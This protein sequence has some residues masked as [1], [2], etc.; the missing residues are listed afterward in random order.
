MPSVTLTIDGRTVRV[1][2][3][4]SIL[5]A[6]RRIGIKLPTMCHVS[7]CKPR[8]VCRMCVVALGGSLRLVPSCATLVTE[9]MQVQTD[10]P[11]VHSARKLLMEFMLAEHGECDDPHC[12][13]EALAREL[14]V[15]GT[16]FQMENPFPHLDFSSKFITVY[17]DNCILCDRCVQVCSK[18][19]QV[20]VRAGRGGAVAITFDA[21]LSMQDATCTDCGDC[22]SVCPAGAL[23]DA[24][25]DI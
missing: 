24:G 23:V 17:S 13:I 2:E 8:A 5:D 9:G 21:G 16:R 22:V 4:T 1:P 25:D 20:V 10:T 7:G 19:Q 12:E 3:E 15:Q 11:E 18:D 14:G 6:A